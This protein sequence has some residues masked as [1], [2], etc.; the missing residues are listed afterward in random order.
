[1]AD[2]HKRGS[3]LSNGEHTHS[4]KKPRADAVVKQEPQNHQEQLEEGEVTPGAAAGAA[5]AAMEEPQIELMFGLSRF[6]CRACLLPLKPP[7]LKCGAGH[8]VCGACRDS[9]AQNCVA[10]AA[11]FA[12]CPDVDDIVRDAKLQCPN[13]EHGCE[14]RPVYYQAVDHERACPWAPCHC[15]VPGCA[16]HTSPARLLDH[17]RADHSWP[18]K[19]VAY[20]KPSAVPFPPPG[21]WHVLVG[22]A[23]G[24]VFLV[25]PSA[26]GAATAVSLV[27]VRANGGAATG[28]PQFKCKLW[29]EAPGNAG[30]MSLVTFPVGSS[31]LSGGLVAADQGMFL[32][33]PPLLQPDASGEAVVL[34]VRIDKAGAP[35]AR[36]AT[37]PVRSSGRMP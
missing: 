18:V 24:S 35:M 20:G 14:S 12:S 29:V 30:T 23:D 22:Q 8:I 15:P 3:L 36:S 4:A 5:A 19:E 6:H 33:V 37:P 21:G 13:K 26:L 1:M 17:F 28:A 9:H 32:V 27:C 31:D 7:T 34:M 10:G 2:Q 11:A 25:S 16:A